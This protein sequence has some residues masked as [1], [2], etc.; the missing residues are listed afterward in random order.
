[1]SYTMCDAFSTVRNIHKMQFEEFV[2]LCVCKRER[3]MIEP[4]KYPHEIIVR[5]K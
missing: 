2:L 1:M 3:E 5:E 4:Q